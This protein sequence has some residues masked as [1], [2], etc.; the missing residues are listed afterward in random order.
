[1]SVY[2]GGPLQASA[3]DRDLKWRRI[4]SRFLSSYG[5]KAIN[6]SRGF[7]TIAD[8]EAARTPQEIVTRDLRD[9]G[10]ADLLLVNFTTDTYPAIGTAIEIKAAFDA[11]TPVIAVW[12]FDRLPVFLD[13]HAAAV[14]D[15]L[16]DALSAVV[17]EW[18]LP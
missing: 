11:G 2:L 7:K 4:A 14:F 13:Y 18:M 9:V 10:R 15:T 1:M 12:P 5:I 8:E 6:P 3:G 17:N 16:D